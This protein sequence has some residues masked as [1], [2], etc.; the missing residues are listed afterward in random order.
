MKIRETIKKGIAGFFTAALL[1]GDHAAVLAAD[2]ADEEVVCV[3]EDAA[4]SENEEGVMAVSEN[5]EGEEAVPELE[6]C[7]E[8]VSEDE[9]A[10]SGIL[11]GDDAESVRDDAEGEESYDSA[12]TNEKPEKI[13][14]GK[15]IAVS[16]AKGSSLHVYEFTTQQ[17]GFISLYVQGNKEHELEVIVHAEGAES[18]NTGIIKGI[19]GEKKELTKKA[20]LKAGTRYIVMAQM[21]N[22]KASE[23]TLQGAFQIDFTESE[24]WE[25]EL[26]SADS[27]KTILPGTVYHGTLDYKATN[28]EDFYAFEVPKAGTVK[29]YEKGGMIG[30]HASLY[31]DAKFENR[32]AN[33]YLSSKGATVIKKN[34]AAGTY[35][36]K[37]GG[38]AECEYEFK[39]TVPGGSSKPAED[40]ATGKLTMNG[41]DY[42]S[43]KAAI[44]AMK[45]ATDYVIVLNSD[46][47]GEK[48]LTFPKTPTSVT[49]MGNGHKIVIKGSKVTAKCPM[50]I[51]NVTFE[52]VHAKREGVS[53]KLIFSAKQGL[54]VGKDVHFTALST[55][56]NVKKD[57]LLTGTFSAD[58]LSAEN[59][60]LAAGSVYHVYKGNKFTVKKE[61][62]SV[63]GAEIF[64]HDGFK[65][66]AIKGSASGKVSFAS[67]ANLPDGIQIVSC[68]SKKIPAATLKEV[69]DCADLTAN[70]TATYLYY[71][72][73]S[74]ACMFGEAIEF[75]GN[76]Y[77]LWKD[78]VADMNAAVKEAA[79]NKTEVNFEVSLKGDVNMAGKFLL[80]KK[81]YGTLT[82]KGNGHSISFTSDIKLTGNLTVTDDTTLNKVN[83]KNEKVAGKINEG[84]FTYSGPQIT[85]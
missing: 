37:I 13:E 2:D 57:M 70:H 6:A 22:I 85:Q 10:Q 34:L 20:G 68:S 11:P 31:S 73:G 47:I 72:S 38:V 49:I 56:L 62:I 8:A 78:V 19:A 15:E 41:K 54:T 64:L 27:Y 80:P 46:M 25:E 82:I 39:V 14:F 71:L 12:G 21:R 36:L 28:Y 30:D 69:F 24:Y 5:E 79:K 75:N 9:G 7:E 67:D 33:V 26:D 40:P 60:K 42:T 63:T 74:K 52:T 32:I 53:V 66:L 65:P 81:G 61:F 43:V 23:G 76:R 45:E 50:K 17:K 44:S 59:L 55:R 16:M 77:G 1:L 35:Y 51:E 58:T 84:K 48:A 29:I 4:V 18:D 3:S 83:K